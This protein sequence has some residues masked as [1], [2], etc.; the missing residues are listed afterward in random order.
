MSILRQTD[1]TLLIPPVDPQP[2]LLHGGVHLGVKSSNP[3]QKALPG[4][5]KL[6]L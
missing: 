3:N 4:V 5:S 6:A 1:E 2:A